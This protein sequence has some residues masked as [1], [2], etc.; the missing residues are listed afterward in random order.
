MGIQEVLKELENIK[1]SRSILQNVILALLA[2]DNKPIH[3]KTKLQKMI[4]LLSQIIP[5]LKEEVSYEAYDYGMY[6]SAV[7]DALDLLESENLIVVSESNE[8]R[9]MDKNSGEE[10]LKS[11]EIYKD[12][13]REIKE[14]YNDLTE[15]EMLAIVYTLFPE[16]AKYSEKRDNIERR[17]KSIAIRLYQK[18]KVSLGLASKIAKMNLHDFINLLKKK[19]I[20]IELE[21]G[22]SL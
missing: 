22:S 15:D 1:A 3:G 21:D 8:I 14:M 12:K 11:L 5:E 2:I 9:L 7:E 20:K 13:I 4:F 16:Y 19:G 18:G 6:D 10:A 17:R